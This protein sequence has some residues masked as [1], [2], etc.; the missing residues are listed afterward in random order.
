VGTLS[1]VGTSALASTGTLLVAAIREGEIA[2]LVD[3]RPPEQAQ[4]GART[5]AWNPSAV[6]GGV[7]FARIVTSGGASSAVQW[8]V[9][10]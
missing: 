2:R 3:E 6:S 5:L 4:A 7:Y 9:L 1:Q 10:R 8:V